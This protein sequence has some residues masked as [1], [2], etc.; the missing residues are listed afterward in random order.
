LLPGDEFG[1]VGGGGEPNLQQLGVDGGGST[2]SVHP[3][4]AAQRATASAMAVSVVL[5]EG[6]GSGSFIDPEIGLDKFVK[7]QMWHQINAL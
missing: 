2:A 4:L 6:G 3:A 1:G 5:G 7:A